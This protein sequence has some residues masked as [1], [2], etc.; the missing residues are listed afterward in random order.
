MLL[1]PAPA[2][3]ALVTCWSEWDEPCLRRRLVAP[4]QDFVSASLQQHRTLTVPVMDCIRVLALVH[5]ANSAAARPLP[6]EVGTV[7]FALLFVSN[8]VLHPV[9]MFRMLVRSLRCLVECVRS[10]GSVFITSIY[11]DARRL[12]TTP[13]SAVRPTWRITT[14]PG[15]TAAALRARALLAA[16]ALVPTPPAPPFLSAATL[17]CWMPPP[18]RL[19]WALPSAGSSARRVAGASATAGAL[20]AVGRETA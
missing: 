18:R 16:R 10:G 9:Y 17:S 5:Q 14:A 19:C 6:P 20:A 11:T 7:P 15:A 1:A 2:R 3:A 8:G 4:L 12:F 13:S